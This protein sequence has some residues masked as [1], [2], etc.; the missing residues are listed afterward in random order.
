MSYDG[1]G[2]GNFVIGTLGQ[3]FPPT[4]SVIGSVMMPAE[5]TGAWIFKIS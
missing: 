4:Q 1:L 2:T 3:I 5:P